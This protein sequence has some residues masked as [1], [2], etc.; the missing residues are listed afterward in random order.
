MIY[1]SPSVKVLEEAFP[2]KGKELKN[3]L[4]GKVKTTHYS[5]VRKWESLCFNRPRWDERAMCAANQILEGCGTEAAESENTW[6]DSFSRYFVFSYINMGYTYIT[7]L[8]LDH[9]I[10]TFRVSSWG[11]YVE[12]LEGKGVQFR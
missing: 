7:T 4:S 11:D 2:G 10:N 3:L 5:S 6:V 8:I 1:R 9:R 12:W